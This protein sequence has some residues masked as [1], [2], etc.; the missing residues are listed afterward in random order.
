AGAARCAEAALAADE[1]TTRRAGIALLARVGDA[2]AA[3]AGAVAGAE[4]TRAADE[5]AAGRTGVALLP[6]LGLSVSALARAGGGRRWGARAGGRACPRW[7]GGRRGRRADG[8]AARRRGDERR[9]GGGG[10]ARGG[11][12]RRL[13]GSAVHGDV[14]AAAERPR[15]CG[16]GQGRGTPEGQLGVRRGDERPNVALGADVHGIARDVEQRC[17]GPIRRLE[18]RVVPEPHV[19]GDVDGRLGRAAHG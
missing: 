1:C 9:A 10:A 7:G 4:P 5:A 12:G 19:T 17:R 6:R 11:G 14:P 8:R 15:A 2:V 3:V 16:A 13:V 18:G